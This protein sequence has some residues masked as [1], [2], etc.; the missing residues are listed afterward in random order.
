MSPAASHCEREP[1]TKMASTNCPSESGGFDAAL[2]AAAASTFAA[3]PGLDLPLLPFAS[4]DTS[5]THGAL[6]CRNLL[7][8]DKQGTF[9][10]LISSASPRPIMFPELRRRLGASRS[11][12]FATDAELATQL[13]AMRGAVS[14][15][16]LSA[17]KSPGRLVIVLDAEIF[18]PDLPSLAGSELSFHC[19]PPGDGSHTV[20]LSGAQLAGF[21]AAVLADSETLSLVFASLPLAPEPGSAH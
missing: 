9:F 8:K 18:G 13:G 14:P 17:R 15:L 7:V 5:D 12:S 20:V 16:L 19:H 2:D 4:V 21:F 10:L 6:F 1:H 11:L 3:W